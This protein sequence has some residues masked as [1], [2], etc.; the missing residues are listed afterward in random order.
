MKNKKKKKNELAIFFLNNIFN[1]FVI[2]FLFLDVKKNLLISY[3][4]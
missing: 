4:K 3:K 1:F 2:D